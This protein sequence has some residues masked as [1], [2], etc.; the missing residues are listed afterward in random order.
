MQRARTLR[1][2]HLVPG[3]R[4]AEAVLG[5]GPADRL[6]LRPRMREE[7]VADALAPMRRGHSHLVHVEPGSRSLVA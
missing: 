2:E 1:Y 6:R 7:R 5:D 4:F 3:C